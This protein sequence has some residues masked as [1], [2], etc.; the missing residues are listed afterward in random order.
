MSLEPLSDRT[1]DSFLPHSSLQLIAQNIAEANWKLFRDGHHEDVSCA[2]VDECGTVYGTQNH[3]FLTYGFISPTEL[4]CLIQ[5]GLSRTRPTNRP[6]SRL[7][8]SS[9][10]RRHAKQGRPCLTFFTEW[11][12]VVHQAKT[13][14]NHINND[15]DDDTITANRKAAN[16]NATINKPDGIIMAVKLALR[17]GVGLPKRRGKLCTRKE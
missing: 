16:H 11:G 10:L 12:C 13:A 9:L 1:V 8:Y 15:D 2:P 7:R 17:P 6:R 3:H 14:N 4:D 5:V